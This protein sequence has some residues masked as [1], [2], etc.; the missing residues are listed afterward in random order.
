MQILASPDLP[1]V[2]QEQKY[3]YWHTSKHEIKL[4]VQENADL[5]VQLMHKQWMID[6]LMLE[7]CPEDMTTQ[8]LQEYALHQRAVPKDNLPCT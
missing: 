6:S 7:Y 3:E 5:Q 2:T 1:F 8:Q 4:L